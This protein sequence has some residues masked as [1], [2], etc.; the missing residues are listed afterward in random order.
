[1][2][3]VHEEGSAMPGDEQEHSTGNE[4]VETRFDDL[5]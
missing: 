3:A 5:G 2:A 1:M 4:V